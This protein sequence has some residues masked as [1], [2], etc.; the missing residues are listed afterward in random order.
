MKESDKEL[1]DMAALL[2]AG[3]KMLSKHCPKCRGPLFEFR[4][5]VFCPRCN[6]LHAGR[7]KDSDDF[8]GDR[9]KDQPIRKSKIGDIPEITA[10]KN[11]IYLR[12]RTVDNLQE[13]YVAVNEKLLYLIY[14]LK[15]TKDMKEMRNI[16][17]TMEICLDILIKIGKM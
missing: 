2:L 5:N 16:L 7:E 15:K 11:N 14:H 8:R 1:K 10:K 12:G 17:E 13:T 6:K 9:I 4:G 3:A